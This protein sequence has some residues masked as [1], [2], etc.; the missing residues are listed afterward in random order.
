MSNLKSSYSSANLPS[1]GIFSPSQKRYFC[2]FCAF[3]LFI[4]LLEFSQDYVSSILNGNSFIIAESLSYKLFW[5]LFIPFSIVLDYGMSKAKRVFSEAL[6]V[7]CNAALVTF[8]TTAHLILFSLILFGFSNLMHEN[9]MTLL[10]LIYEKLST[11]LYIALSIYIALSVTHFLISR[12]RHNR[13]ASPKNNPSSITVKNGKST[14]IVDVAD[15]KWIGSDGAYLDI[16]TEDKKHVVL[17]SL[18]NMIKSLPENFKRIHRS[19]IVNIDRITELKSRGNGDY[20]V[21]MDDDQVLRLSRNYSKN[22]KG[23]LL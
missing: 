15:I 6:Y 12:R 23:N 5:L 8:V 1:A 22:L 16:Y 19:T 9:P 17:D 20:D 14:V 13:E 18:K 10:D 21:V 3:W 2:G 4:A 11:R 7:F